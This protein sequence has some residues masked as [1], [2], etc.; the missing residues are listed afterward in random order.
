MVKRSQGQRE[1]L[2]TATLA[3]MHNLDA[4]SGYLE[5][6]GI[7]REDART[8]GLGVVDKTVLEYE[9][10]AG[11]LAIPYLTDAGPVNMSFRCMQ[12]HDCKAMADHAK[13]IRAPGMG[14]N[15]YNVQSF[16]GAGDTM[17]ITEGEIDALTCKV[18]GIPAMGVPGA[19]NWEPHWDLVFQDFSRLIVLTDG[20]DAGEKFGEKVQG[21]IGATPIALPPGEDVNSMYVKHG[22]EYFKER[23]RL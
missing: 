7:S 23:L 8:A 21:K 16:T 4:V 9:R 20:D 15:L 22:Y 1:L 6:R 2:E 5:A 14:V 10:F 19:K 13:Y 18:M 3:Y 17:I 12:S 11:R